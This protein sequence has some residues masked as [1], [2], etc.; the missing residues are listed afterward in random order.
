LTATNIFSPKL[1]FSENEN[2]VL[3]SFSFSLS[4]PTS[5]AVTLMI[6]L[7]HG[8]RITS[9]PE[10]HGF[11]QKQLPASVSV[12]LKTTDV[13]LG[14]DGRLI[15]AFQS[16]NPAAT[17]STNISTSMTSLKKIGKQINVMIVP[18]SAY[19]QCT[20]PAMRCAIQLDEEGND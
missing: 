10:T 20:R 19:G 14:K 8:L 15:G 7:K 2:R 1:S 17:I 13:Y 9:L 18:G 4:L 6:S 11:R 12:P 16:V 5:L 3:D